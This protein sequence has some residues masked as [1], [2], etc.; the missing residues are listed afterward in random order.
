MECDCTYLL[1]CPQNL[2]N[3]EYCINF[4]G[5]W[6]ERPQCINFCH[7]TTNSPNV[8]RR[9]IAGGSQKDFRSPVP[10]REEKKKITTINTIQEQ[11][12]TEPFSFLFFP[13]NSKHDLQSSYLPLFPRKKEL[14]K[15][16]VSPL[17]SL[18]SS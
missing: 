5:A 12:Y 15:N 13:V 10:E 1:W 2:A 3:F 14:K 17:S 18:I 11:S 4:T 8:Y 6:E 7:Y 9:A 16:Y